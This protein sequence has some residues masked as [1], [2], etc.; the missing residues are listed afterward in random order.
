M[1]KNVN[2]KLSGCVFVRRALSSWNLSP[3]RR[4]NFRVCVCS[5]WHEYWTANNNDNEDYFS[6]S[7]G[8]CLQ[9]G[10]KKKQKN[11]AIGLISLEGVVNDLTFY[12][13]LLILNF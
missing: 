6:T 3:D 13:S 8:S 9:Y 12:S 4:A 10:D 2:E 1:F 11:S 7:L 5:V